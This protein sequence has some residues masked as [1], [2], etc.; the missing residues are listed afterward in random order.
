VVL[1]V[2]YVELN[3]EEVEV[4]ISTSVGAFVY[5]E[6]RATVYPKGARNKDLIWLVEDVQF[7]DPEL[8]ESDAAIADVDKNGVVTIHSYGVFTVRVVTVEGNKSATCRFI[9]GGN[10]VTSI[11]FASGIKTEY[12][13][14]ESFR[15]EAVVFSV[16]APDKSVTW[17]S[18]DED[19][20]SVSKNGIVTALSGGKAVITATSVSNADV[21]ASIEFTCIK[22]V[23]KLNAGKTAMR[24]IPLS[25]FVFDDF[26]DVEFK[27]AG[28]D[29]S[30]G[31]LHVITFP[32]IVS[33]FADDEHIVLSECGAREITFKDLEHFTKDDYNIKVG[34]ETLYLQAVYADIFKSGKPAVKYSSNDEFVASIDQNGAV[35]A[36]SG[37]YI[38]ISADGIGA[39]AGESKSVNFNVLFPVS[40]IALVAELTES[41]DKLGIAQQR[42]FGNK[43]IDE[44]GDAVDYFDVRLSIPAPENFRARDFIWTTS[45]S[46]VA[47]FAANDSNRLVFSQTPFEGKRSVRVSVAAR[48]PLYDSLPLQVHYTFTVVDGVNVYD[49]NNLIKF[50]DLSEGL[51]MHSS[52]EIPR[53]RYV[54]PD[55]NLRAEGILVDKQLYGNGYII[56]RELKSNDKVDYDYDHNKW[57]TVQSVVAVNKDNVLIENVQIRYGLYTGDALDKTGVN[58][59]INFRAIL[60]I[61]ND[62]FQKNLDGVRVNYTIVENGN[63]G[64][65]TQHSG[66]HFNGCIFRNVTTGGIAMYQIVGPASRTVILENSVFSNSNTSPVAII[67]ASAINDVGKDLYSFEMLETI[68]VHPCVLEMRGFVDTY[69]WMTKDT[70]SIITIDE[71]MADTLGMAQSE[72]QAL[73]DFAVKALILS[74]PDYKDLHYEY[75]STTYFHVGM[76]LA[77]FNAPSNPE[78]QLKGYEEADYRLVRLK[79]PSL[80]T[81]MTGWRHDIYVLCYD[82]DKHDVSYDDLVD[83]SENSTLYSDL[84]NGRNKA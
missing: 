51:V 66:I 13:P 53:T 58:A 47:V 36:H 2:E 10:N 73:V 19:V 7:D 77:G 38:T 39:D 80:L 43:F 14:G 22:T 32:V 12:K 3:R 18:S 50:A 67:Y 42:V 82:K 65:F 62:D 64:A 37:G 8:I 63:T 72:V 83:Y 57:W 11:R 23:F 33:T 69:M 75:N 45:D 6:L 49:V 56:S 34:G 60:R 9:A 54:L 74:N 16:D 59:Y 1:P 21:S 30:N 84:R 31:V 25:Y 52:V 40:R 79:I 20:F 55:G 48:Y 4:D 70:L 24:D 76:F 5:D 41:H 27:V 68:N 46:S 28:G 35:T 17:K 81:D 44:N 26:L 71:A 29:I 15:L 78:A 61:R